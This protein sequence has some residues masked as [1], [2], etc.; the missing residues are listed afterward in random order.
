MSAAPGP[1]GWQQ[2]ILV[3]LQARDAHDGAYAEIIESCEVA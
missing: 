1:A 2:D 3:R